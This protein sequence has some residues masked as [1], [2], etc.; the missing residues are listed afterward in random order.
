MK[1]LELYKRIAEILTVHGCRAD[2]EVTIDGK[3]ID[4]VSYDDDFEDGVG[5]VNIYSDE[6]PRKKK[7]EMSDDNI[8]RRTLIISPYEMYM[9]FNPAT[10]WRNEAKHRD[11]AH[12][13]AMAVK[14]GFDIGVNFG[15]NSL[16]DTIKSERNVS[17]DVTVDIDELSQFIFNFIQEKWREDRDKRLQD[18]RE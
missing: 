6:H 15:I 16:I 17:P 10:P 9:G 2:W 1:L 8:P 13:W 4:A 12:S 18:L 7:E 3:S 14:E 5:F 11:V